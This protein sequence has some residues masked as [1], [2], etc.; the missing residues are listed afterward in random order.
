MRPSTVPT[1][2]QLRAALTVS[3]GNPAALLVLALLQA[4]Y[5]HP[6]APC[7]PFLGYQPEAGAGQL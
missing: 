1:T 7:S 2:R 3:P 6:I 5:L 4:C